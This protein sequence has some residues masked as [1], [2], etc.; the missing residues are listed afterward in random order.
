M[1]VDM[2]ALFVQSKMAIV[3]ALYAFLMLQSWIETKAT[4]VEVTVPVYPVKVGGILAFQCQITDMDSRHIVKIQ[5]VI[6][7]QAEEIT[8]DLKYLSTVLDQRVF[9]TKRTMTGRTH[10]YFMT[11]VDLTVLDTGTYYCKVYD[12]PSGEYI[13]IADDSIYV[14]VYYLP[15]SI[16]PQCQ[17]TPEDTINLDAN[18]NLRLMCISSKGIPTVTLQWKTYENIDLFPTK[19]DQDGT[20]SV[21][22]NL[23]ATTLYDGVVFICEMINPGLPDFIR[24][25]QVGP[26]T[27]RKTQDVAIVIPPMVTTRPIQH[28]AMITTV[29]NID[30]PSEDKY[31]VLYLSVATIAASMLCLVFLTTTIIWCCKYNRA[32]AEARRVQKNIAGDGSEP[33]YVS[34]QT[35]PDNDQNAM[36]MSVDDPNNPGNKVTM[37]KEVFDEFY[38]SLTLKKRG[39]LDENVHV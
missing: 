1:G 30:C 22:I 34:L 19:K 13:K 36:I 4:T 21:E 15:D 35:R 29:C 8:S 33:V 32:S 28:N 9:V 11:I 37:P 38:R 5:R 3:V 7:G 6:N 24:T 26:V 18:A 16:Y 27:I 31:M 10:V 20:I 2:L 12:F 39:G 14:D 17:S 25:C 23:R